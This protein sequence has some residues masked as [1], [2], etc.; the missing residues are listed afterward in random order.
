MFHTRASYPHTKNLIYENHMLFGRGSATPAPNYTK[1][2][3]KIKK[4][5]LYFNFPKKLF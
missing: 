4:S 1:E 2:K 3:A 5:R